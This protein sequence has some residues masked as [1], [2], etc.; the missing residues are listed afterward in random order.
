MVP[1]RELQAMSR[2]FSFFEGEGERARVDGLL[3]LPIVFPFTVSL[4]VV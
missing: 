1:K 2:L 3:Y 4:H